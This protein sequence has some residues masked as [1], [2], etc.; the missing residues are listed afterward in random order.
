M[1]VGPLTVVSVREGKVAAFGCVREARICECQVAETWETR[2][3]GDMLTTLYRQILR[4]AIRID[5]NPH[6]KTL[7]YVHPVIRDSDG[8]RPTDIGPGGSGNKALS[9]SEDGGEAL[10]TLAQFCKDFM[11]GTVFYHP[12]LREEK[13]F[14]N[15]SVRELVRSCFD[16]KKV[17]QPSSANAPTPL[18]R[19]FLALRLLSAV[20]AMNDTRPGEDASIA[21]TTVLELRSQLK[22]QGIRCS[23]LEAHARGFRALTPQLSLS[24]GD[25][26]HAHPCLVQGNL[27]RSVICMADHDDGSGSLGVVVNSP[28]PFVLDEDSPIALAAFSGAVQEAFTGKRIWVGG[29]VAMG[30]LYCI[31]RSPNPFAEDSEATASSEATTSSTTAAVEPDNKLDQYQDL[32]SGVEGE[33]GRES[34]HASSSSDRSLADAPVTSKKIT[35]VQGEHCARD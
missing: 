31:H 35:N 19:G 22:A 21:P 6:L 29:D 2:F 25:F 26:L 10:P 3:T 30:S 15:M 32:F 12:H 4:Y 7:L 24:S 20:A 5:R 28:S 9:A 1:L 23:A 16:D 8:S 13:G 11:G 27:T 17:C 14:G 33:D 18:E 34:E